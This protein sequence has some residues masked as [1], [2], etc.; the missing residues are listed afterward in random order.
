MIFE[1][2]FSTAEQITNLSGRGVGMDVVR[3]NIDALRGEVEVESREGE[4]ATVRIRL[5]L[6]LA[7][8]DGFQV[9]VAGAAF[10]LPLEMVKE[11]A[12]LVSADVYRNLVSLRGEPLPFIRLRDL[13][14]MEGVQPARESLVVVQY[15]GQRVGLVV[16][17]LV[18][19][20][21]AVIKPLGALFRDMRGISGS[22]ILGNGQ[23]ALILDVPNLAHSITAQHV[24]ATTQSAPRALTSTH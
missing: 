23:V 16:D 13:F 11:C 15:G 24:S 7:I 17:N 1:A 2:G 10:V 9:S 3:K 5:P 14:A 18:G 20:L 19:E 6:T 8:I 22:T 4:G 12:D 21:Q